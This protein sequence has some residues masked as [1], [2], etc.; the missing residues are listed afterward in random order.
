MTITVSAKSHAALMLPHNAP[1]VATMTGSG[2]TLKSMMPS[3]SS[4]RS[5]GCLISEDLIGMFG[6]AGNHRPGG[7]RVGAYSQC[8]ALEHI[9][10]AAARSRLRSCRGSLNRLVA[11]PG[12]VYVADLVCRKPFA[13]LWRAPVS[14]RCT[15]LRSKDRHAHITG[16]VEKAFLAAI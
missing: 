5:P 1:S 12:K 6:Q 11:E 15:I 14:R 13:A 9:I 16:L 3:R 2:L 10:M 7:A 8:L 4:M